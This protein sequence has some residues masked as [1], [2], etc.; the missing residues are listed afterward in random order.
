MAFEDF[1]C[2][3]GLQSI[4]RMDTCQQASCTAANSLPC[5]GDDMQWRLDKREAVEVEGML[6]LDTVPKKILLPQVSAQFLGQFC[7][8]IMPAMCFQQQNCFIFI[9][10]AEFPND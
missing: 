7:A 9:S 4:M 6:Q 10:F 2:V 1:Q 8:C 3:D 5:A